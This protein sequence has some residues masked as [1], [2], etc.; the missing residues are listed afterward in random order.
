MPEL[1]MFRQG[2]WQLVKDCDYIAAVFQL[3]KSSPEQ[4]G[5]EPQFF[6]ATVSCSHLSITCSGFVG[7]HFLHCSV[8]DSICGPAESNVSK[9]NQFCAN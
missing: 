7:V 1:I 5:N 3:S 9:T 6:H 8:E 2:I 4:S